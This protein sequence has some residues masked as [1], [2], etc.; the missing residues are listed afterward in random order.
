MR[1]MRKIRI[2]WNNLVL[3][4]TQGLAM[5][6]PQRRIAIGVNLMSLCVGILNI[7]VGSFVAAITQSMNILVGV[8][9]ETALLGLPILFNRYKLYNLAGLSIYWIMSVATLFFGTAFGNAI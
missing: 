6:N 5:N 8:A 3:G 9:T 4:G 7:T 2:F 1:S